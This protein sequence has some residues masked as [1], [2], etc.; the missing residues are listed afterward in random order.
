MPTIVH[1]DAYVVNYPVAGDFKFFDGPP[2]KPRG[3]PAV[4]VRLVA[5]EGTVGLGQSVPSPRWSYETPETVETTIRD[6]LSYEL[7]GQDPFDIDAL[8][9]RMDQAIAGSF[10]R[11]QPICK[12]G[13]D[14]A[15]FDLTGKLLNQ[16]AHQRWRRPIGKGVTLSWTL[17]PRSLDDLE[18]T[19]GEAFERGYH[20]F[21]VKVAPNLAFDLEVCRLVRKLAPKAFLWV[22]ANGGYDEPT[23]LEA[24]PKFAELGVFAFEQPLPANRL[25]GYSRLKRQR[26]LPIVMDEGIVSLTDLE[27]FHHL[28]LLDGVAMKVARCGGL[29][30]ARSQIEYL[31]QHGLLFMASG[32]TDPDL[33]LAASVALFSAY[34]L[35][36]PAALNGPQ[37]LTASL[38]EHPLQIDG[39][40]IQPPGGP[41]LGVTV[42]WNRL[43]SLQIHSHSQPDQGVVGNVSPGS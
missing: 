26:A 22:D 18:P 41:G 32:L 43:Q 3:R 2:G 27:E 24:A 8:Q 20:H 13:L 16:P 25:T 1:I 35:A 4:M 10:S 19:I 31:Q 30:E 40:R 11:G 34:E 33:S 14:L 37:F 9:A 29:T 42:D 28:E 21:N 6:Y 23:A 15:L 38:M 7:L 36:F 12:S 5:D 17:N 39:D